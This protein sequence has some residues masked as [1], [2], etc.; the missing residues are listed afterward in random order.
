MLVYI[1]ELYE[2]ILPLV[3]KGMKAQLTEQRS[4]P[5]LKTQTLVQ[6]APRNALND[7][8]L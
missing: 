5:H 3:F 8:L 4:C 2:K 1:T 6:P 7:S